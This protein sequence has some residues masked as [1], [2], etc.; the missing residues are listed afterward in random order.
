MIPEFDPNGN[1]P[2]GYYKPT[3]REF[4]EKFV[5]NY[6]TSIT[7]KDIF[8]NYMQYCEKIICLAI[9]IKQWINGSYTTKKENPND[10]DC[11]THFEASKIKQ[12]HYLE[13]DAILD[14]HYIKE[15]FNCDVY[16]IAVYPPTIPDKYR[17]YEKNL[18][19]WTN[20]F[21]HDRNGN[22]KGI[23]ELDMDNFLINMNTRG[24][25]DND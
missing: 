2:P 7:R 25:S 17:M 5:D 13:L 20:L 22:P 23:I 15:K 9:A 1:L 21:G 6:V 16:G 18:E 10:I 8:H 24:E 19:Y 14:N 11:I 3:I 4:E 12:E